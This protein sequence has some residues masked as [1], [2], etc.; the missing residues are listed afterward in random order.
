MNPK[1]LLLRHLT[2]SAIVTISLIAAAHATSMSEEAILERIAPVGSVY[3]EGEAPI[4]ET[5]VVSP[6]AGEAVYNTSCI[7]CHSTGVA[8]AP[9]T[10]DIA[11][12]GKRLAQGRKMLNDHAIN[13]FNAM[14]ARGTC[15]DCSDKEIIS[16]INHMLAL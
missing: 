7:A 16:A 11:A 6:R 14:P 9:K 3:L 4:I 15:F 8:G 10:G 13:G 12:W 1:G 2:L 5:V